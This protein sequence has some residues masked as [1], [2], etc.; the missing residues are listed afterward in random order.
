MIRPTLHWK[1]TNFA[2]ILFDLFFFRF[3]I[4]SFVFILSV[5]IWHFDILNNHLISPSILYFIV[6]IYTFYYAF[7]T[8]YFYL[9]FC[10]WDLNFEFKFWII[11]S[12]PLPPSTLQLV[13]IIA[14]IAPGSNNRNNLQ[15]HIFIHLNNLYLFSY[16]FHLYLF[17]YLYDLYYYFPR[18]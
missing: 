18:F 13:A 12:S 5:C 6:W 3:Y 8:S 2:L 1:F 7:H 10:I 16:L 4:S 11:T 15:I 14:I 9:L 17:L